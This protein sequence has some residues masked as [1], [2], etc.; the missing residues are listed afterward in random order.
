VPGLAKGRTKAVEYEPVGPVPD[1]DVE[2]TLPHLPPVVRAMVQFQR[3]TGCRPGEATMLRPMDIDRTSAVWCY[4][5][6]G[7]K[8]EHYGR[9][10]RIF[11]GPRA[12]AE[13]LP[14]LLRPAEAYCFSPKESAAAEANGSA[15][16]RTQRQKAHRPRPARRGTRY[17]K[18]SYWRAINRACL[19]AKVT[20]WSPNQLRHSSATA[21]R[22]AYGLEAAQLVLGH[23]KAD[24][25]Q[26]YAERDFEVARRIMEKVG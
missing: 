1:E 6:A 15:E 24:V 25:T 14:W 18:D 2:A 23:A 22:K 5:P 20:P 7:H 10:R 17:T 16:P 12:Q 8:T 4:T 9:V 21:I 3:L 26:L 11:I 13:L 19:R